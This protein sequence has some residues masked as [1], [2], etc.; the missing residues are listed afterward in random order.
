MTLVIWI[1]CGIV[2]EIA[3]TNGWMAPTQPAYFQN[4]RYKLCRPENGGNWT[5]CEQLAA[6]EY[7]S[8]QAFVYSLD[9]ILPLVGLQQEKDWAP[10][11][12]KGLINTATVSVY[13]NG[14]IIARVVM[15]IEILFGWIASL[16]LVAVLSGLA[17]KME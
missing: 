3:A 7:T 6:S 4:E 8:F 1:A 9:L 16:L 17:K 11:I 15:W 5:R 10:I 12:D 13:F 2:F 14:G